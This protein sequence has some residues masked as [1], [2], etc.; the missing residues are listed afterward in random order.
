[1]R[2]VMINKPHS[3]F[4]R[5]ELLREFLRSAFLAPHA[6]EVQR[7][8]QAIQVGQR[9]FPCGVT[10]QIVPEDRPRRL[11]P[12][13]HFVQLFRSRVCEIETCS[14]GILGEAGIVLQPA[15]ALFRHSEQELAVAHDARRRVMHLR[16]INR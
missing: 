13:T 14:N 8:I 9:H 6:Q 12:K 16:I 2:E 7:R 10:L 11:P 5:P 4:C 1:M 3:R 15:D